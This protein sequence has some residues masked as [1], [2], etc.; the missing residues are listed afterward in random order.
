[1]I[2]DTFSGAYWLLVDL[3][4]RNVYSN[5]VPVL[6]LGSFYC[7]IVRVHVFWIL[8]IYQIYNLQIFSDVGCLHFPGSVLKYTEVLNFGEVLLISLC[9]E[10]ELQLWGLLLLCVSSPV[11]A[12]GLTFSAACGVLLPLPGMG[13]APPCCKADD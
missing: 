7:W 2:L 4:W 13:P 12:H 9:L 5:S 3:I 8:D 6:R 10:S 1:M 11:V